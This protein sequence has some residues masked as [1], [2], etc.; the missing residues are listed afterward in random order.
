MLLSE[1]DGRLYIGLTPDLRKRIDKHE[2]GFVT[3]TKHRRPLQLIHYEAYLELSDAKRREKYLKGG[4]GRSEL[5]IQ[6]ENCF[7]KVKYKF[8]F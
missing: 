8:R 3:A 5:K 1:T 4:K 2:R 6:L 7:A